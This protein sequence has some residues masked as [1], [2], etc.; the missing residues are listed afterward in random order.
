MGN[1]RSPV[2]RAK[3]R[4][5]LILIFLLIPFTFVEEDEE[6]EGEDGEPGDGE[7]DEDDA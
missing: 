1:E 3:S 2:S 4:Q 5:Q 6:D 7:E